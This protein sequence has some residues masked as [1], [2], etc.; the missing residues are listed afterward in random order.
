MIP[1]CGRRTP[2]LSG[3]RRW[4]GASEKFRT[5]HAG[6]KVW[7]THESQEA[8]PLKLTFLWFAFPALLLATIA[9]SQALPD[10]HCKVEQVHGATTDDDVG[11]ERKDY[12]G[13]EFMV[14]R[15]T[16][17]MVGELRNSF[18]TTPVVIDVGTDGNA[19]KAVTIRRREQGGRNSSV[20]VLLI[21][22]WEQ[23]PRKRFVFMANEFIY[24]GTCIHPE[25]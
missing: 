24:L 16:G 3:R 5:R 21:Q 6:N 20:H 8:S 22:E 4:C 13:T 1:N 15:R 2:L 11:S 14:D 18:L 10:Y 17:V 12:V 19:F 25:K 7:K 9:R 23:S